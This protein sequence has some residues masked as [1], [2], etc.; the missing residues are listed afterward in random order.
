MGQTTRAR[1]V[2]IRI[3]KEDARFLVF[4][5]KAG[6][7]GAIVPVTQFSYKLIVALASLVWRAHAKTFNLASSRTCNYM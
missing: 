2:I 3:W 1:R 5:V 7:L 6:V 4:R